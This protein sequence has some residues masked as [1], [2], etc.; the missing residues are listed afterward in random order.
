MSQV[1]RDKI[2]K[3]INEIPNDILPRFYKIIHLLKEELLEGKIKET[4]K[5]ASLKGIWKGSEIPDQLF[6]EAR[7]SLFKYEDFE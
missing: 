4:K 1:Y 5:R 2:I 6:D 3:E 7:K